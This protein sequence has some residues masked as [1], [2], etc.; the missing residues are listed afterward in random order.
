MKN[1]G[2]SILVA[3]IKAAIEIRFYYST[4]LRKE[5]TL[6]S[7]E[8]NSCVPNFARFKYES[9][10]RVRDCLKNGWL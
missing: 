6:N 1:S 9:Y 10:K 7:K 5:G 2:F 4:Y 3:A 8:G